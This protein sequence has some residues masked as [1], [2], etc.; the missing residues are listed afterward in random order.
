MICFNMVALFFLYVVE[1]FVIQSMYA[2][3]LVAVV[4]DVISGT[5]RCRC[6]KEVSSYCCAYI[7][8][9]NY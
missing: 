1:F 6:R 3:V 5:S 8:V 7:V 9:D 4:V 2:V